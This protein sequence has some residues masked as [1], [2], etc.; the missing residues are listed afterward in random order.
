ML[1]LKKEKGEGE[2]G[3]GRRG[4]GRG[5]GRGGEELEEAEK[6]PAGHMESPWNWRGQKRKEKMVHSVTVS[7]TC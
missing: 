4:G 3:R 7:S 5:G 2:R 1:R 6:V